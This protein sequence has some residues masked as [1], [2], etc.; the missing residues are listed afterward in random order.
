[1]IC[2]RCLLNS[3]FVNVKFNRDG[4][5][6]YCGTYDDLKVKLTDFN[7]NEKLLETRLNSI[8]G[9]YD[10][11][12]LVGISGGKDSSYVAYQLKKKYGLKVLAFTFDNGFLTDYARK[13]VESIL[14]KLN[15]EH[16]FLK[17]DS[18][19]LKEYFRQSILRFGC[20][21][22]ACTSIGF[23]FM[24]K[25]AFEKKI[26]LC[27][28]GYSRGQMF[29]FLLESSS[30]PLL[31]S[32]ANGLLSF[33]NLRNKA[34]IGRMFNN[35]KFSLEILIKDETARKKISEILFPDMG[36]FKQSDFIPEFLGYF[37]Y[38][39]YDLNHILETIKK[40]LGWLAS[41]N[42]TKFDH[43]DCS[44]HEAV[45]YLHYQ[46]YGYP[47]SIS[48]L[49]VMVREGCITRGEALQ[50]LQ[51]GNFINRIPE[52]SLDILCR[53]YNLKRSE[54]DNIIA[55][56]RLKLKLSKLARRL[57]NYF[58]NKKKIETK[59]GLFT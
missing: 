49:S 57:R 35:V 58:P 26:P 43:F 10:Y 1:M 12:C 23:A 34:I 22:G 20:P 3:K 54:I 46:I 36:K 59:Y 6:N 39:K 25:L 32:V 38:E 21:C 45:S 17:M 47:L 16:I 8:R 11:D 42:Q 52:K 44:I 56:R 15:I 37:L 51:R 7:I 18:D 14:K 13:N 48:Q 30:D 2:K 28:H 29:S 53:P 9:K 19:V 24:N 4:I 31:P 50:E 27:F 41:E 40:E 5:C 55:R 33:D